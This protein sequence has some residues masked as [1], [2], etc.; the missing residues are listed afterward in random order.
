MAIKGID[1]HQGTPGISTVSPSEGKPA[2][3]AESK[4]VKK[5]DQFTTEKQPAA[6]KT[7]ASV[8]AGRFAGSSPVSLN[9][10][11][12]PEEQRAIF[13]G[14]DT[15]LA[16]VATLSGDISTAQPEFVQVTTGAVHGVTSA[17]DEDQP[18]PD[19]AANL[20][21]LMIAMFNHETDKKI[22]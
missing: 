1:I 7:A 19:Q 6:V 13:Q 12:S 8:R 4:P 18:L 20:G 22:S 3:G 16:G 15:L 2:A 10:S 11:Y 17:G 21:N 9:T 14:M 5:A